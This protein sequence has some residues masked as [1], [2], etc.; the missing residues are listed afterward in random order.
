GVVSQG[1][2]VAVNGK[3]VGADWYRIARPDGAEAYVYAPLFVSPE[4]LVAA[5]PEP[6]PEPAPASPPQP[7]Q[8]L[9]STEAATR[10]QRSEPAPDPAADAPVQTAAVAPGV[11]APGQPPT[12]R[13]GAAPAPQVD[14]AALLQSLGER[15][16]TRLRFSHRLKGEQGMGLV[17]FLRWKDVGSPDDAP[18]LLGAGARGRVQESSDTFGEAVM[19]TQ[20][21]P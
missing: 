21:T 13:P 8:A 12:A 3:V 18:T 16:V 20:V 5:A 2:E 4:A 15:K 19:V 6:A 11:A 14:A 7:P 10:A 9:A 1:T 17:A